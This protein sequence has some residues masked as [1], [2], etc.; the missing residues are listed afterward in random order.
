MADYK[1][2]NTVCSALKYSIL[3]L[4]TSFSQIQAQTNELTYI[5]INGNLLTT[6]L[7][8]EW[9]NDSTSILAQNI[10]G[11][12]IV[13]LVVIPDSGLI[14]I[15]PDSLIRVII[16][17]NDQIKEPLLVRLEKNIAKYKIGL[18]EDDNSGDKY[19]YFSA[20]LDSEIKYNKWDV[21]IVPIAYKYYKKFSKPKLEIRIHVDD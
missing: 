7:E 1:L 18:R 12:T 13:E 9:I 15:I 5:L 10:F 8:S 21:L 17:I 11:E 2:N 20:K 16:H 14:E 3:F 19:I 4:L 6:P